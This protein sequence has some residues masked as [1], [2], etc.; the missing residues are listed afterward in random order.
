MKK[1][2][3]VRKSGLTFAPEAGSQRL[4]DVINKNVTEED[5]L[6]SCAAAFEGGWSSVK[7]YFMLGL[8][9]ETD[10]DILQIA[11][12]SNKVYRVWRQV[13][14]NRARG[15]KIT[16]STSCFV[17]KPM[18]PFQWCRQ[19]SREE[20]DRKQR[21]LRN[22]IKS[23]SITYNWHSPTVSFIEAVLARG[24]RRL[25]AV[26]EAVFKASG[27]LKAWDEYFD[28][29]AWL[30]AF[31]DCGIDP[32]FYA[33]RE[34]KTDEILP[35]DTISAG[36]DKDF[37]IGEYE[38]ALKERTSPDCKEACLGCGAGCLLKDGICE[39]VKGI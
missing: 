6:S 17:P 10:E 1:V 32:D 38:N 7:L 31:E 19:D 12:L 35:W 16:V 8:P 34:R 25:G 29:P 20:F 21:L 37:L 36:V 5:I 23:K 33:L 39:I 9:T 18:T 13:S 2:Q 27:G 3:K 15:V 22:A 4:R 14:P 30:R 24:D 11:D 26:L 28:F